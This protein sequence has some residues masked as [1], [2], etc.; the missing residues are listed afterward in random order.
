MKKYKFLIC[1]AALLSSGNAAA[2][3]D[4]LAHYLAIAIENNPRLRSE[5]LTYKASEERI[6]QAGA[7]ADPQL[8][9]GLFIT[10]MEILD[11]KQIAD[12]KLMQMFPWFGTRKAARAEAGEMS[13]MYYEQFLQARNNLELEVKSQWYQLLTLKAK[14]TNVDEGMALLSILKDLAT[15]RFAAPSPPASR[16]QTTSGRN[17]D[18]SATKQ[19][20]DAMSAM[21]GMSAGSTEVSAQAGG[22]QQMAAMGGMAGGTSGGS[23]MTQVIR[24]DMEMNELAEQ[25]RTLT[26]QIIAARAKFNT[27]LNRDHATPVTLSDTIIQTS[28]KSDYTEAVKNIL[29][30]NPMLAMVDAQAKSYKAKSEMDK[31]MSLPMLGVGIQYSVIGK[32]M[33]MG[34]PVTEMNG[35]DM[36]MPM[37]S[38]TIPIYR[39]KYNAQQNES[40]LLHQAAHHQYQ[41]TLNNLIAE[42][43]SLSEQLEE[44]ARKAELYRNQSRLAN[45][46]YQLAL[47]EFSVG[48]SSM[49]NVIEIQRQLL[50]YKFKRAEAIANYNTLV[51]RIENL[52]SEPLTD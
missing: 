24:V 49:S 48:T 21:A 10:P 45:V 17:T 12:F 26:L 36:V 6:A 29:E 30:H 14:L 34:I 52:L 18:N 16:Q 22:G 31:K 43:I 7:L 33:A 5:Y 19:T 3:G 47:G 40:R 13:R 1:L 28:F 41:N 51:A 50:D 46:S 9:V 11:G 38:L 32:R 42:Y 27:L 2:Q 37:V 23:A 8:E 15:I 39:K 25:Q 35:K 4:S 44:A 20:S